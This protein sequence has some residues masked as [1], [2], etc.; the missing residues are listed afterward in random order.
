MFLYIFFFQILAERYR[1]KF[2]MGSAYVTTYEARPML[3]TRSE[4]NRRHLALSFVEAVSQDPN[5]TLEELLPAYRIAGDAFL[6]KMRSLFLVLDD[7]TAKKQPAKSGSQKKKKRQASGEG[8][9][10]AKKKLLPST[11]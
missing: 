4:R 1:Q 7:D 6:G 3:N 10:E 9:I 11:Q 5:P 2:P 8:S